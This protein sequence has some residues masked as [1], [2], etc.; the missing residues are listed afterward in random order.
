MG[1]VKFSGCEILNEL[2]RIWQ[3]AKANSNSNS[4]AIVIL[5]LK[6]NNLLPSLFLFE[7]LDM[8]VFER[9]VK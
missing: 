4:I 7:M 1:E 3:L 9:D 2:G 6:C 8:F 5:M